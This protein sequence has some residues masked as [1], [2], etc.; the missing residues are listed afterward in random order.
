MLALGDIENT[1]ITIWQYNSGGCTY[2]VITTKSFSKPF[3]S[4]Q[5]K[6]TQG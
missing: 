2:V 4:L 5:V 3:T 1:E 6:Y